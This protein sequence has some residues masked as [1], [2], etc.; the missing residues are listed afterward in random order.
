MLCG[1]VAAYH[2]YG[3][4]TVRCVE[5]VSGDVLG[6]KLRSL[7]PWEE[8]PLYLLERAFCVRGSVW[9]QWWRRDNVRPPPEIEFKSLC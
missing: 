5:C 9:I 7:Y 2:R 4:C 3:V 8:T 1:G 6:L